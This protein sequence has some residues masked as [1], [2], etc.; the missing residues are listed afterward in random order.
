MALRPIEVP[1]R[2]FEEGQ[3]HSGYLISKSL[4]TM[5][6]EHG[7]LRERPMLILRDKGT[8]KDPQGQLFK[9]FLGAAAM[10]SFAMLTVGNW[11]VV[12]KEKRIKTTG[13]RGY[14]PYLILQDDEDTVEVDH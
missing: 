5:A 7:Q 6:D 3:E 11:T 8:K 13:G 14:F 4:S 9:L 12:K 10:D 2:D 1:K